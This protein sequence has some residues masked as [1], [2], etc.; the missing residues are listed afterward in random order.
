MHP[1]Q[2]SPPDLTDQPD[3][4]ILPTLSAPVL[5]LGSTA[6]IYSEGVFGLQEGKTANGLVRHSERYDIVSV[7]DST[8]AGLDAGAVLT[9]QPLDIPVVAS[10]DHAAGQRCATSPPDYLI[11]GRE[12]SASGLPSHEPQRR[13]APAM[14]IR[15]RSIY[16]NSKVIARAAR[17]TTWSSWPRLRCSND[18]DDHRHPPPERRRKTSTCS[19]AAS[20]RSPAR[21][22][23]CSAQTARSAS[24]RP[25][26][27]SCRLCASAACAPCSSAP[28]RRRLSRAGPTAPPSTRW[29]PSFAPER[30]SARWCEPSRPSIRMSSSSRGR[31]SLSH[32]AYLSSGAIVRGSQPNAVI[33]QHAPARLV[34]DDFPFMPMPSL[35]HEIALIELFAQTRVIGITL[36]HEGMNDVDVSATIAGYEAEFGIPA[37]DALTRPPRRWPTLCWS[38]SPSSRARVRHDRTRTCA[39]LDTNPCSRAC[40]GAR[41]RGSSSC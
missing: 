17:T 27:C 26:P 31:G 25:Q 12:H 41:R 38:P 32:P 33:V 10:L 9:G 1:H 11:L 36:N 7:I 23:P 3:S 22:S 24:A 28:A 30:L 34:R 21:V 14:A 29:C 8:H 2:A 6:V 15:P 5:P 4:A 37:T 40:S 20:S 18:R 35:A 39:S 16:I 19:T 13:R